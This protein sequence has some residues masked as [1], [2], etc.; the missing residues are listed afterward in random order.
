M[1][2]NWCSS[3]LGILSQ[4]IMFLVVKPDRDHSAWTVKVKLILVEPWKYM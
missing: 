2:T 4:G 1:S 3:L